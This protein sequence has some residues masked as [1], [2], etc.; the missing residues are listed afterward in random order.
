MNVATYITQCAIPFMRCSG[1]MLYE[2]DIKDGAELSSDYFNPC[3]GPP[4]TTQAGAVM[5]FH[6]P[7]QA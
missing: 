2:E 3:L 6:S 1:F 4:Y 5:A 7:T